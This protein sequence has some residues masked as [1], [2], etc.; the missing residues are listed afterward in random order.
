MFPSEAGGLCVLAMK[1]LL[2]GSSPLEVNAFIIKEASKKCISLI[3]AWS[4]YLVTLDTAVL[5]KEER[6]GSIEVIHAVK[7]M[8]ETVDSSVQI[9]FYHCHIILVRQYPIKSFFLSTI[10]VQ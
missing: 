7:Q 10:R 4:G 2:K 6:I 5:A 1:S 3:A 8:Y 9:S